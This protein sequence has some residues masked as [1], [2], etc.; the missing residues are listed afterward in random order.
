VFAVISNGP[1]EPLLPEAKGCGC[2]WAATAIIAASGQ[3]IDETK[4]RIIHSQTNFSHAISAIAR[5]R[6]N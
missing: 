3:H 6:T 1:N 4:E 5:V 2:A